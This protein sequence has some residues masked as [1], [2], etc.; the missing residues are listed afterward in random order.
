LR[1]ASSTVSD[2]TARSRSSFTSARTPAMTSRIKTWGNDAIAGRALSRRRSRRRRPPLIRRCSRLRCCQCWR[3]CVGAFRSFVSRL[4]APLSDDR[5][6]LFFGCSRPQ[7][8]HN[9]RQ[10]APPGFIQ[11]AP[12]TVHMSRADFAEAVGG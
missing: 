4:G 8:Y 2:R 3:R 10:R 12:V 1:S 7:P 9:R 5:G 11:I 6:G